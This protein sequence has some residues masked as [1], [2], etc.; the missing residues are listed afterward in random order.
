LQ[1]ELFWSSIRQI[2]QRWRACGFW[3]NIHDEIL[4]IALKKYQ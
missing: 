4:L 1:L 2:W 3:S